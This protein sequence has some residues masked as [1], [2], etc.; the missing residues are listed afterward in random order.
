MVI[1]AQR[2]M[3]VKLQCIDG[4]YIYIKKLVEESSDKRVWRSFE[5]IVECQ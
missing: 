4:L 3:Y 1:F 5:S 2:L